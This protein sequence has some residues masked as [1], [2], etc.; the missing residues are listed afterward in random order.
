MA[1]GIILVLEKPLRGVRDRDV[2]GLDPGG[3]CPHGASTSLTT[4]RE[5]TL[6]TTG[7]AIALA[8]AEAAAIV[9]L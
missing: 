5:A 2:S 8:D 1:Y 4:R 7:V 6:L 3:C 9:G